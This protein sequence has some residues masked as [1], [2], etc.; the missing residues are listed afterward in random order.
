VTS[1][2]ARIAV[3]SAIM[4]GV[5]ATVSAAM[6]GDVGLALAARVAVCII[7][8]VITYVVAARALG[9][10]ELTSLLRQLRGRAA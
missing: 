9:V 6:P 7:A 4:A 1:S 5:V 3:A 10:D 2:I 8:G